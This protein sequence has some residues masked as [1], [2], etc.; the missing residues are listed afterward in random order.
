MKDEGNKNQIYCA[1]FITKIG[2]NL[3]ILTDKVIH[4]LKSP[5]QM[6]V[7]DF[8]ALGDLIDPNG[9]LIEGTNPN[10]KMDRL[11]KHIKNIEEMLWRQS[12]QLDLYAPVLEHIGM[13]K[14]INFGEHYNPSGSKEERNSFEAVF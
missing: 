3:R 6:K 11:E 1:Q 4:S 2:K 13:E 9:R 14:G 7:L 8:E 5:I 10:D 12:Y